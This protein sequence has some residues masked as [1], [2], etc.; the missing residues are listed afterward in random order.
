MNFFHNLKSGFN[1]MKKINILFFVIFSLV[2]A[3]GLASEAIIY[4]GALN[5]EEN[6]AKAYQELQ[7]AIQ[8]RGLPILASFG[9]SQV[10]PPGYYFWRFVVNTTNHEQEFLELKNIY[11][12]NSLYDFTIYVRQVESY[13]I[14]HTLIGR[15]YAGPVIIQ[16]NNYDL[17]TVSTLLDAHTYTDDK[18]T[19]FQNAFWTDFFNYVQSVDP[20]LAVSL[21]DNKAVLREMLL[22]HA[23]TINATENE[24]ISYRV[25][26]F[27]K[28]FGG[29]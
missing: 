6:H 25:L 2:T 8:A 10:Y 12:N 16:A 13:L 28:T 3:Q 5:T 24:K 20:T 4:Y 17:K 15:S 27:Y 18:S 19:L 21:I 1:N 23:I 7:S 11:H 22:V 9:K 29:E 26:K 14:G